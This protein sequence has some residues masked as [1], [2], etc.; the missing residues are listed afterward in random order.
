[1][2]HFGEIGSQEL[3][4]VM[5]EEF[6]HEDN[7]FNSFMIPSVDNSR[8]CLLTNMDESEKVSLVSVNEDASFLAKVAN[9]VTL[10]PG[11]LT[12]VVLM[13]EE[14]TCKDLLLMNDRYRCTDVNF[15]NM[16][17]KPQE[18]HFFV[19]VTSA[20]DKSVRLSPGESFCSACILEIS[21]LS[22][23][24]SVFMSLSEQT[25]NNSL[26]KE[27][28][29]VDFPEN[30]PDLM[31]VLNKYRKAVALTGEKLGRTDVIEHR[32]NLIDNSKPAFVPNFR[33][34][35]SRRNIV[36]SLIK[37]MEDQGIIKELLSPY[38]SPLLLVP[39]KDGTWRIVI[40][41]K[42]LNKDTIPDRMPMPNFDEVLSQLNGTKLFSA[43]DLLSGY[44]Q[45]PLSEDSKQ[46]TA[47]STHNL[48]WQFEVMPFGL[49]NAPLA[50]VRL[51]HQILGNMKNVF[52]YLDDIIIF[53]SNIEE[54]FQILD[55]VLS[56]LEKAG[57][58]IKLRKCQFLKSQLDFLG[59]VIGSNGVK[60]QDKKIET[61]LNYPPPKNAKVVKRFLEIICYYRP[62]VRN[63]ATIAYPLTKLLRKDVK[64][65][66]EKEEE[67]AFQDLKSRLTKAPVLT[68]SDYSKEFFLACDASDV[69]IGA[70][71]LQKGKERLM[72]I[73]Y[74][75]RT[76]DPSERRYSVTE[77]ENLTVIFGLKKIR[78]NILGFKIQVITD[79]KPI[80]DLSKKRTFTNNQKFNSYFM[81]ILEYS[82]SFRYIP[83]CFNKIADG[84][85]RLSE[86]ELANNVTF[87]VQIVD[88]DMDRIRIEQDK[89]ELIRK[90]KANLLLDPVS[91]KEYTL[92]ND[93]VYL[94]PVKNNKCCRLFIPE[95][96]VL[97]ILKICHSH[98]LAG[99]PGIQKTCDIVSKNYFWP[100]CSQQ[101]KEFVLNCET[102][103]L[104]KGK[105][106]KR[107]PL[108]SYP[109]DLLPFQCVSMNTMGPLPTTDNG[110]KFILVFV[111]FLSR[112]TEIVPIKDRTSISVAEALRHRVITRHSCPQTLLSNNALEFT[113]KLFSKSCT[114]YNIKKCNIIAHKPSSNGL[115]ERTNRKIIE[116]LTLY[117]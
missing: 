33:L 31:R 27:L 46:C 88:I 1:M 9:E 41:Y 100:H 3:Y 16:L 104:S 13:C 49:P 87:T 2:F 4:N 113:S 74:A 60:M 64:F 117:R 71:L 116:I 114:F 28:G 93:C 108:E 81:S 61:I 50:F 19:Y 40:D 80:L 96:L 58:K 30:N 82:P 26:E 63:F 109:S 5:D 21:T 99:H 72:P 32:I 45:V 62:F 36:E 44:H 55:E 53:S 56:R 52:V 106:M 20:T 91:A 7:S 6:Y 101:T 85:S 22:V 59:H 111:D 97:K 25:N 94:K 65:K 115:V 17:V 48:H 69:G 15:D 98:S 51:M 66:W 29:T 103:Q 92:I 67:S 77:R 75:S 78:H 57:L 73:A 23:N 11:K 83:G 79:H 39:K 90:I 86:D 110:N 24:E 112:Y 89:D 8:K 34:P 35:V 10:T 12:K 43:L 76:L 37:D 68:Y 47:F 102:C 18:G 42:R 95:T 38:N 105:V 54:H 14:N 107:A 70:V 84:L